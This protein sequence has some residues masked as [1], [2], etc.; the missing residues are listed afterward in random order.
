MVQNQLIPQQQQPQPQMEVTYKA[1]EEE[2]TLNPDIIKKYLVHGD[3]DKVTD[4]EVNLFLKLCQYQRLNPFLKEAY[5]IKYGNS[6]A[7]T[8]V[9]KVALEKRAVRNPKYKGFEAGIFLMNQNGELL[10]RTGTL[11]LQGE[12]IVGGWARVYV[13]GYEKPVEVTVSMMEYNTGKSTW[14]QKPATMIRKVAKA[15]ALRE[16]FP[17]D[18]G[19]VYIQEEIDTVHDYEETVVSTQQ[20]PKPEQPNFADVLEGANN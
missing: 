9:G 20:P 13:E 11:H 15:Q 2:V 17:E 5:L 1:G 14:S 16:A 3:A 12:M 10:H 4:Q 19:N 8:I 6:P 7:Q 18:F